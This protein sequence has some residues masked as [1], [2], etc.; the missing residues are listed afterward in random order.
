MKQCRVFRLIR[1]TILRHKRRIV[2][3]DGQTLI[4]FLMLFFVMISLSFLLLTQSNRFIADRWQAFVTVI[5][6]PSATTIE[7]P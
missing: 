3:E 2:K 1:F 5:A 4:E 6:K 7:L